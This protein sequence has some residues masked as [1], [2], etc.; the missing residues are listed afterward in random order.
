[1]AVRLPCS[2]LLHHVK[3]LSDVTAFNTGNNGTNLYNSAQSAEQGGIPFPKIPTVTTMIQRNYTFRPT[4]FGC[5]DT[6]ETPLVL[7]LPNAPWS[8][9]SNYTY[10]TTYLTDNQMNV[11]LENS[12]N[13]ATYG[14]GQVPA[15][16]GWST[17]LACAAIKKSVERVGME[18]PDACTQCWSRFCWDGTEEE[19]DVETEKVFD[20]SPVL[21]SGLTYGE[22]YNS[23]WTKL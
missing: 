14:N 2:K 17:C 16:E 18:L 12:F 6:A 5:N 3:Y 13:L 15:G 23:T 4:F 9:Y 11:T 21:N 22:W 1:M 20:L 7:Y 8:S 19:G 10:K